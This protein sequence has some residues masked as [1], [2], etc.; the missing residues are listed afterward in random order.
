MHRVL[1]MVIVSWCPEEAV[2]VA[3]QSIVSSAWLL[4]WAFWNCWQHC[5]NVLQC[6]RSEVYVSWLW[7]IIQS[8]AS[9]SLTACCCSICLIVSLVWWSWNLQLLT[10]EV[11]LV[12]KECIFSFCCWKKLLMTSSLKCQKC[13]SSLMQDYMALSAHVGVSW[14][15]GVMVLLSISVCNAC[16]SSPWNSILICFHPYL[17]SSSF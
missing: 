6:C 13:S 10:S 2:A 3:A 14:S 8:L 12:F 1:C 17:V 5:S 9:W 7:R 15:P 16:L 11:I 4:I